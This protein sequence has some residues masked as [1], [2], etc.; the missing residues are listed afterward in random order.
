MQSEFAK[1][2]KPVGVYCCTKEPMHTKMRTCDPQNAEAAAEVLTA[3]FVLHQH[4]LLQHGGYPILLAGTLIG[5]VRNGTLLPE[6]AET[7]HKTGLLFE[8]PD[9]DVVDSSNVFP[10]YDGPGMKASLAADFIY[11]NTVAKKAAGEIKSITH[12]ILDK[13]CGFKYPRVTSKHGPLYQRSIAL[14]IEE[15]GYYKGSGVG[16][17]GEHKFTS[18][19]KTGEEYWL[20]SSSGLGGPL[21]LDFFEPRNLVKADLSYG[22]VQADA[23]LPPGAEEILTQAYGEWKIKTNKKRYAT[24]TGKQRDWNSF[25]MDDT[26]AAAFCDEIIGKLPKKIAA[27]APAAAATPAAAAAAT[28]SSPV[29]PA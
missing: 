4:Y 9:I 18:G 26:G 17:Q 16:V 22:N 13:H 20:D 14:F 12:V 3:P 23:Y 29:I 5:G 25:H 24:D 28:P 21:C 10:G 19:P 2:A 1:D 15:W 27:T 11:K 6:C 8:E 7:K